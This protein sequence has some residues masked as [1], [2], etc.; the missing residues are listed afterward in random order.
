LRL[1]WTERAL[2]D[3]ERAA[4]WSLPQAGAAV[5]AMTWMA[6]TGFSLGRKMPG[7]GVRYYWPVPPLGAFYRVDGDTLR[8]LRVIDSRRRKEPW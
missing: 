7:P 6:M 8:V 1:V 3:L 5:N 4:E 2:A